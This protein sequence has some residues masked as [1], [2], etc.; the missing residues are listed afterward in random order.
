MAITG[1]KFIKDFKGVIFELT[2]LNDQ[3]AVKYFLSVCNVD[4]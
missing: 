2:K 4:Y 3:H 1:R